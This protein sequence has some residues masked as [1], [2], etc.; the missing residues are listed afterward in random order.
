M[1]FAAQAR[2]LIDQWVNAGDESAV[3]LYSRVLIEFVAHFVLLEEDASAEIC[4]TALSHAIEKHPHVLW[5][6]FYHDSF[7]ECVE[8][9]DDL[10]LHLDGL[11]LFAEN[12]KEYIEDDVLVALLFFDS[13]LP[14]W[15]EIEGIIDWIREYVIAHKI[16]SPVPPLVDQ[17]ESIADNNNVVDENINTDDVSIVGDGDGDD[18]AE[19]DNEIDEEMYAGMFWT[20][21]EMGEQ[22]FRMTKKSKSAS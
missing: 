12:P 21:V 16:D 4:E 19:L 5:T 3:L 14:L 22:S 10:R 20:A 9:I 17:R 2:E 7:S 1:G 6:L 18:M 13:E 15:T 11:R 8:H